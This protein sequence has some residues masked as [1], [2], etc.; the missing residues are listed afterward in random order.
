MTVE[1]LNNDGSLD[2]IV[3]NYKSQDVNVL[4]GYGNGSFRDRI[5]YPVVSS[6]WFVAV[7]DFNNDTDQDIV[8]TRFDRD[9]IFI[10]FG[11]PNLGFMN[12]NTLRTD[13]DSRPRSIVIMAILT[14]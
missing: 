5:S 14:S 3:I 12:Q 9:N 10:L 6:S 7:G 13:S 1:D 11:R 4:L 2:I 8:T